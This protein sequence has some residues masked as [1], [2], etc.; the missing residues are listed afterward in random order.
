MELE[1]TEQLIQ[2]EQNIL[3]SQGP[4]ERMHHPHNCPTYSPIF[5]SGPTDFN[6]DHCVTTSLK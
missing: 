2:Q 6:Q 3:S 1:S 4:T 5:V